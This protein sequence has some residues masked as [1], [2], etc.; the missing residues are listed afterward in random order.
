MKQLKI[1]KFLKCDQI[2]NLNIDISKHLLYNH[3]NAYGRYIM[4]KFIKI[5]LMILVSTMI[6]NGCG[7]TPETVGNNAETSTE[8]T[9]QVQSNFYTDYKNSTS[10]PIAVMIDNDN[11]DARPHA[12]IEDAY[13][14]YE[15]T[16]EGSAT[17]MMAFFDGTKTEKIGPVRS[18]R[19]YFLDY[20]LEHDAIYT[21]YGWSP[22]AEKD[23]PALGVNNING[24][25]D[26]AF[27][28]ENKYVGDYH[29]A[30]TS[31][32]KISEQ[33]KNKSYR[34]ERKKAPLSYSDKNYDLDGKNA[35]DVKIPYA[36]F[37][38]V[39]YKYIADNGTYERYINGSLH[40]LQND[41]KIEAKNIIVIEMAHFSLGDGSAR[42]N[43]S[44]VGSG[45]G[46]FITQGKYVPITWSKTSRD[47]KTEFKDENGKEILLN[48]GQ[49]WIQ[50]VSNLSNLVIE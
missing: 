17:R 34:T 7:K 31:I 24:L 32:E 19:H 20:A 27:W 5:P 41:A 47:A 38:K 8:T 36:G 18:S 29:S 2:N 45:K 44:D 14:V 40:P 11:D 33:I 48:H 46:Y 37:Y 50:V 42:I 25:F 3:Y 13:L 9:E 22:M 15:I 26:N 49:T 30:F 16:V 23:I 35:N 6:L 12:G 28:R 43:I 21:H 39:A 1:L 10:R 4:K